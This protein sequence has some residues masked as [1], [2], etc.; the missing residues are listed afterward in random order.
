MNL[1]AENDYDRVLFFAM[2][3]ALAIQGAIALYEERGAAQEH[4]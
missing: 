1:K 4:R 2:A 3:A